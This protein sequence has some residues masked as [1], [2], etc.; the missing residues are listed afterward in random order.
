MSEN[1]EAADLAGLEV[2]PASFKPIPRGKAPTP[3]PMMA[4]LQETWDKGE[5]LSVRR[6]ARSA[7]AVERSLRK[8]AMHMGK[9]VTVQIQVMPSGEVCPLSKLGNLDPDQEVRVVF[10]AREL[11][12]AARHEDDEDE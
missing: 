1:T 7:A 2:E 8:A 5:P 12:K 4:P 11:S 6:P 10:Q 3:N 9:G